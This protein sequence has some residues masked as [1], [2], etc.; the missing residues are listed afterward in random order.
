M[1]Q[2]SI[3][4]SLYLH[5][6]WDFLTME[7]PICLYCG[8]WRCNS[9]SWNLAW[10]TSVHFPVSFILMRIENSVCI[11]KEKN[12]YIRMFI[13]LLKFL[14]KIPYHFQI[15]RPIKGIYKGDQIKIGWLWI[16]RSKFFPY[17]P[18]IFFPLW[19]CSVLLGNKIYAHH[20]WKLE[21]PT[22]LLLKGGYNNPKIESLGGGYQ[23]FC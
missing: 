17:F 18:D 11:C 13:W 3:F 8:H 19:K 4:Y 21:P 10:V 7:R 16:G 15:S 20:S 23:I 22:P 1:R 9:I 2:L 14:K 5:Q 6:K 12:Y